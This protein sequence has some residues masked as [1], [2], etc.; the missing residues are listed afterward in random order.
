VN[1]TLIRQKPVKIFDRSQSWCLLVFIYL[2]NVFSA[3]VYDFT[4]MN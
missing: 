2:K 3:Q 1:S 4:G